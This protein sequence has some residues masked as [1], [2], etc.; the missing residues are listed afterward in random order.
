MA[1]VV[2]WAWVGT[3]DGR[4]DAAGLATAVTEAAG[5]DGR[6]ELVELTG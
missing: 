6:A 1:G 5:A 4:S 2:A 3:A